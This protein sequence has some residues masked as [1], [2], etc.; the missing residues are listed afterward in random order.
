MHIE[1]RVLE[2]FHCYLLC[3]FLVT[4]T[5][6]RR[7]PPQ[8]TTPSSS[9]EEEERERACIMKKIPYW[10]KTC[11]ILTLL[12]RKA[13]IYA[14]RVLAFPAEGIYICTQCQERK[15]LIFRCVSLSYSPLRSPRLFLCQLTA[16]LRHYHPVLL[17]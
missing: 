2:I 11:K 15:R 10:F 5:P 6:R 13:Y 1:E 8:F 12:A 17:R 3:S 4:G 14:F 9:E 7:Y 16:Y